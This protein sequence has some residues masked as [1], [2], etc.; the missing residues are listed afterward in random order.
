[1]LRG[2]ATTGLMVSASLKSQETVGVLSLSKVG[3]RQAGAFVI[4]KKIDS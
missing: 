4:M 2:S 3:V 1:M